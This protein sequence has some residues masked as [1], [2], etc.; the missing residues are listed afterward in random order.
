M[1][2]VLIYQANKSRLCFAYGKT[3]RLSAPKTCPTGFQLP[4]DS[5]EYLLF[6]RTK[7][8]RPTKATDE[9]RTKNVNVAF[10]ETEFKQLQ[11]QA[12][13]RSIAGL[14]R[15]QLTGAKQAA[16]L[17]EAERIALYQLAGMARNLNQLAAQAN[18]QGY[19]AV[20]NRINELADKIRNIIDGYDRKS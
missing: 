5:T 8:A 10:T 16:P 14:I 3:R 7:M 6:R 18:A 12:G 2:V 11:E 19:G 17:G 4:P 1:T 15:Q 9:K 20:A 13:A